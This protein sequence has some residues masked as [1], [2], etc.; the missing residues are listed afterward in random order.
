MPALVDI[1]NAG[2]AASTAPSFEAI[3]GALRQVGY[4]EGR[5]IGF[6]YPYA[7][8]FLDRLPTTLSWGSAASSHP[9]ALDQPAERE[10]AQQGRQ[11]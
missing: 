10:T 3:R 2:S 9:P 8:G 1:L 7:D 11:E 4:I 6:A 5:N